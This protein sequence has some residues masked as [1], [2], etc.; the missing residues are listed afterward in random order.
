MP[1]LFE[2]TVSAICYEIAGAEIPDSVPP[3]NDVTVFVLEQWGRMPRFLAWPLRAATLAF[4]CSTLWKGRL[5]HRL[6]P[7]QRHLQFERWRYSS[8]GPCRDLVRFYRSLA[9]LELWGG[10]IVT[11]PRE[12][13]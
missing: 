1:G 11:K 5:F 9:L 10:P 13:N 7:A 4:A 6:S 2:Y 3:Y 8:L 12:T